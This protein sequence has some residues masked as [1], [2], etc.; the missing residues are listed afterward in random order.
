MR[1][2]IKALRA[3]LIASIALPLLIAAP[4]GVVNLGV[5]A[6]YAET[7]TTRVNAPTL[8]MNTRRALAAMLVGY[9][10]ST[11]GKTKANG[12]VI[13]AAGSA[14]AEI[15]KL[16][17]AL[18]SKNSKD[19]SRA[20]Q[21]VSVAIGKLQSTYKLARV[22]DKTVAEGMRSVSS[23][24]AAYAARYGLAKADKRKTKPSAIQV[25]GLKKSVNAMD[26]RLSGL[27]V[28]AANDARLARELA[29]LITLMADIRAQEIAEANYQ[30]MLFRMSVLNGWYLGYADFSE[31]YYPDYYYYFQD[32]YSDFSSYDAYWDGYYDGYYASWPDDYY[33]RDF[34]YP[35]LV[36]LYVDESVYEETNIYV[37]NSVTIFNTEIAAEAAAYEESEAVPEDLPEAESAMEMDSAADEASAFAMDAQ[38]AEGELR[39]IEAADAPIDDAAFAEELA[40]ESNALLEEDSALQDE[41]LAEVDATVDEEAA[42]E[43]QDGLAD[44]A[45]DEAYAEEPTEEQTYEE[46]AYEEPAYEEPAYEEPAYEEPAYEEPAYEE[47]ASDGGGGECY[48]DENGELIC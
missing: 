37:D 45:A 22:Q 5:S 28:M 24:W 11:E 39:E 47:P 23:N 1:P 6:A 2:M 32:G 12:L 7:A 19:I 31:Y 40:A 26:R 10:R 8:L 46:P 41:P 17:K 38:P 30:E 44:P 20:T 27:T 42:T 36:D 21:A 4:G 15:A 48:Y 3:L 43:E 14:A 9:K 29:A 13:K 33:D 16:E 25:K 18:K 34:D 35:D